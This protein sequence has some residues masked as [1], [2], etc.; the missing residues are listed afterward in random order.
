MV[1]YQRGIPCLICL[2]SGPLME[3]DRRHCLM[4]QTWGIGRASGKYA[5]T[6]A[7]NQSWKRKPRVKCLFRFVFCAA[8]HISATLLTY[9]K[10]HY[11]LLEIHLDKEGRIR[12]LLSLSISLLWGW[13]ELQWIYHSYSSGRYK[14]LQQGKSCNRQSFEIFRLLHPVNFL[15]FWVIK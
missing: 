5:E 13:W 6:L 7:K 10:P 9:N 4:C 1:G 3:A 12:R 14:L 8:N 11:L 2:L 15:F